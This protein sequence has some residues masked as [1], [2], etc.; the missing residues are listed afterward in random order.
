M[1]T[2]TPQPGS[3]QAEQPTT[4][5]TEASIQLFNF[6]TYFTNYYDYLYI[7]FMSYEINILKTNKLVFDFTVVKI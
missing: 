3:V 5:L 4:L 6:V 7:F 2:K 1:Q